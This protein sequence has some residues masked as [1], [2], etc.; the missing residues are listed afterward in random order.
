MPLITQYIQAHSLKLQQQI[1]SF[2]RHEIG[3]AV[4]MGTYALVETLF[5]IWTAQPESLHPI[6]LSSQ[7]W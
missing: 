1:A 4:I 7:P 6:A 2:E 3:E 5:L